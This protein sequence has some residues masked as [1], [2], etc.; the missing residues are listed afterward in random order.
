MPQSLF[1]AAMAQPVMIRMDVEL[2][3]FS[4]WDYIK[5]DMNRD[6]SDMNSRKYQSDKPLH[7]AKT[8]FI[9]YTLL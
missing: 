5:V 4:F 9:L 2:E 3:V 7:S 6:F 8:I 1:S